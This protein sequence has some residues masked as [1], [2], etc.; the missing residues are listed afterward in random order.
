MRPEQCRAARAWL[1]WTQEQ[2][3][4]NADVGLSTVKEFEK[5]G[6]RTLPA[7]LSQLQRTFEEAGVEFLADAVRVKG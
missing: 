4:K 6:R 7:I 5:G 3:A 2:L 1:G